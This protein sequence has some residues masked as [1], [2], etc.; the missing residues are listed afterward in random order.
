MNSDQL[1]GWESPRTFVDDVTNTIFDYQFTDA[2][3]NGS[4]HAEICCKNGTINDA[5]DILCE[6]A[7]QFD[8]EIMTYENVSSN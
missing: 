1:K 8:F 2:Y 7:A 3:H 4:L 5:Y 6:H